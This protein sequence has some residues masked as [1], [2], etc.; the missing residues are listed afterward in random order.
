MQESWK[1]IVE[2]CEKQKRDEAFELL[3]KIIFADIKRFLSVRYRNRIE[4]GDEH[5]V[6]WL[7]FEQFY[8]RIGRGRFEY[9]NETASRSYFISQC[10]YSA[11]DFIALVEGRRNRNE[12]IPDEDV[13]FVNDFFIDNGIDIQIKKEEAEN[14]LK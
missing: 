12:Q 2:L 11:E 5:T 4:D 6:F 10:E 1:Q 8:E 3:N 9:Q 7:A 13:D 14:M